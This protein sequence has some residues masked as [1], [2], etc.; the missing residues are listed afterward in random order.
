MSEYPPPTATYPGSQCA[1]KSSALPASMLTCWLSAISTTWTPAAST[2]L[3]LAGPH[4]SE[5]EI[6]SCVEQ[7]IPGAGIASSSICAYPVPAVATNKRAP[8]NAPANND[9]TVLILSIM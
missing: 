8:N 5:Q 6:P 4:L 3:N 7:L 9:L 2:V 1:V